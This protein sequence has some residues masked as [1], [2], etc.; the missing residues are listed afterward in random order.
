MASCAVSRLSI[1]LDV[2]IDEMMAEIT[3]RI[4]GQIMYVKFITMM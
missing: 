4:D 3:G 2:K 1:L